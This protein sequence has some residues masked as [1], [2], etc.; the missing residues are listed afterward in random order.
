MGAGR[1]ATGW[2][3]PRAVRL[4]GEW[5]RAALPLRRLDLPLDVENDSSRRVAEK[6]GYALTTRRRRLR[7]KGREWRMD[8]YEREA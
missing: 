1:S 2:P 3:R 7:A 6:A 8:V 4:L 5:A